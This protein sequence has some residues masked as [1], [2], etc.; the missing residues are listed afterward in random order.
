MTAQTDVIDW[1][2]AMQQCGD[3]EEF[4]REVLADLRT[5]VEAQLSIIAE[6]INNPQG[7]PY[8]QIMRSAHLLKGAAANLMCGALRTASMQLEDSARAAHEQ[9]ETASPPDV[10]A[11]VQAAHR[12]LQ[13]AAQNFV[14]FLF[15]IG[16]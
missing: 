1:Q 15:S 6:I 11:A 9:G 8:H 12:N 2:E 16:L 4:L 5:E 13:Q 3:D 10:Q 14:A 7:T